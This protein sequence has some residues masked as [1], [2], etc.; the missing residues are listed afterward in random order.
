M[1]FVSFS[2]KSL[3]KPKVTNIFSNFALRQWDH[4]HF[5]RVKDCFIN[6]LSQ[7]L[8]ELSSDTMYHNM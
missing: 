2:K 4:I 1:G 8:S 6:V 5:T 3:S 7:C